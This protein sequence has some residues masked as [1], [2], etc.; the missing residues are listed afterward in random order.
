MAY[1]KNKLHRLKYQFPGVE[2][3]ESS[4]S[5]AYQEMFA[6]TM[7]NG[8]RNG[9]YLEVGA[10]HSSKISNTY[11][12]EKTFGWQ[13]LSLDIAKRC[14]KDWAENRTGKFLL[15]DATA[16]NYKEVL[17]DAGL[18]KC[19]D[20]LQ[21]D[22]DPCHITF[23]ALLRIPFEEYSFSV[24]TFEHDIYRKEKEP[25]AVKV[26]DESREYLRS[27]GYVLV[28]GDVAPRANKPFED[29][30]VSSEIAASDFFKENFE[31]IPDFN[32]KGEDY[33]LKKK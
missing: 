4:A 32:R 19:I 14:E 15:C 30:Y 29:W 16:I 33:F 28:L 9:S 18:P 31:I 10:F 21:L 8:K 27:K 2:T 26:R 6:L 23:E 24:I 12:L 11:N 1:T 17:K 20:Y 22:I 3:I 13:G 7:L 25:Y 5:Q